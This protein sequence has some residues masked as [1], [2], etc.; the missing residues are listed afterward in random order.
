MIVKTMG[1]LDIF[2]AIVMVL[3]QFQAIHNPLIVSLGLYLIIKAVVFFGDF[4]SI[5]DGILGLYMLFMIIFPVKSITFIA[6]GYLTIKGI[7]C[8]F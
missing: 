2:T 6:A 4:F 8:L 1:L 7:S 3:F 5:I